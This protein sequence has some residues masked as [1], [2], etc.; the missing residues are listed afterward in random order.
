MTYEMTSNLNIEELERYE[1]IKKL[2]I[3]KNPDILNDDIKLMAYEY[4]WWYYGKN[5]IILPA[6]EALDPSSSL[7]SN[8]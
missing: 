1:N 2:S 7:V 5:D 4:G 8:P 3:S 6:T